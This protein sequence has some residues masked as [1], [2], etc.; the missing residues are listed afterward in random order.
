MIVLTWKNRNSHIPQY[1]ANAFAF[2]SKNQMKHV[3]CR[4]KSPS[5]S[6]GKSRTKNIS[7]KQPNKSAKTIS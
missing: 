5:S 4:G 1:S 7:A 2:K 3:A 6:Q